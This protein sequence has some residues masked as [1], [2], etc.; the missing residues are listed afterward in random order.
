MK[1][2]AH[3]PPRGCQVDDH[4][5]KLEETSE[6]ASKEFSLEKSLDKM[7][8]EWEPLKLEVGGQNPQPGAS[9]STRI[10]L[11][12]LRLKVGDCL[13]SGRLAPYHCNI[14]TLRRISFQ[15]AKSGCFPGDADLYPRRQNIM[16]IMI[17]V[18]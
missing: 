4:M 12:R 6:A 2:F 3:D 10:F 11:L 5:A 15:G 1:A 14:L 9:T 17:R 8:S 7:L 16:G 18:G 13:S